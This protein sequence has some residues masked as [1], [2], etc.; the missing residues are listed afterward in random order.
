MYTISIDLFRIDC[1]VF[2]YLQYDMNMLEMKIELAIYIKIYLN[3]Y[4]QFLEMKLVN[5]FV[6]VKE[7]LFE[8]AF[9]KI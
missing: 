4:L 8:D 5:C 2:V 7:E 9:E 3:F 1:F 6:F